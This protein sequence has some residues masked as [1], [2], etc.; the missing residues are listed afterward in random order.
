MYTEFVEGNFLQTKP[1]GPEDNVKVRESKRGDKMG[2][3]SIH[4]PPQTGGISSAVLHTPWNV[5][6]LGI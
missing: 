6:A 3:T 1:G 5:D 4:P 2:S